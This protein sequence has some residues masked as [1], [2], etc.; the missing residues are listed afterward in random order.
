MNINYLQYHFLSKPCRTK[1]WI[2]NTLLICTV[3]KGGNESR[4]YCKSLSPCVNPS[5]KAHRAK[6]TSRIIASA[7]SRD[8]EISLLRPPPK[9]SHPKLL[10][11]RVLPKHVPS[12]RKSRQTHSKR[13]IALAAERKE[14]PNGRALGNKKRSINGNSAVAWKQ[15][16]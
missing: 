2:L 14:H 6:R 8:G 9:C 11:S 15:R 4:V 7:V 5:H 13:A 3:S 10:L 16:T 12:Q 1:L